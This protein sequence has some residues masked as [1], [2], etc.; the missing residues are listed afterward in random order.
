M[1]EELE[2]EIV[3]IVDSIECDPNHIG[4]GREDT[5]LGDYMAAAV[6]A[7]PVVVFDLEEE[8][9]MAVVLRYKSQ[10]VVVDTGFIAEMGDVMLARTQM[11]VDGKPVEA[12][13]DL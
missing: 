9:A 10:D 2:R 1:D 11:F 3:G 7:K 13:E 4:E 5:P 6:M 8:G 12:A